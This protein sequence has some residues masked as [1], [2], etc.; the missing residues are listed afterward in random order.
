MDLL[1]LTSVGA[2]SGANR[3]TPVARF[4][5]GQGGWIIV[6]SAGGA[7][8][9]PGWYPSIVAHPDQ[10]RVEV[11]GKDAPRCPGAPRSGRPTPGRTTRAGM[12]SGGRT[13]PQVQRVPH[14]DRS[15]TPSAAPDAHRL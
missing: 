4:D 2:R 8:Q 9:H 13:R 14:Q 6:V 5:D 7:T 3:T 10:V 11:S 15:P 12:G 1:Y